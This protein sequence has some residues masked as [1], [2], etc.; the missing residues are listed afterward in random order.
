MTEQQKLNKRITDRTL[1]I[2]SLFKTFCLE[3]KIDAL[4][5]PVLLRK[6]IEYYF[7]DTQ[8]I[9]NNHLAI[10]RTNDSKKFAFMV[11]AINITKPIRTSGDNVSFKKIYIN[12]IF[13]LYCGINHIKDQ[14]IRNIVLSHMKN[15]VYLI[16]HQ[17]MNYLQLALTMDLVFKREES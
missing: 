10:N 15:F 12:E 5:S 3:F 2:K 1:S 17:E 13:S 16:F 11:K 14:N 7:T 9:K 8:V 4:I 6:S